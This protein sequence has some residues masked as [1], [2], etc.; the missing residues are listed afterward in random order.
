MG[1]LHVAAIPFWVCDSVRRSGLTIEAVLDFEKVSKVL[2]TRELV[3]LNALQNPQYQVKIFGAPLGVY[4][5]DFLTHWSTNVHPSLRSAVQKVCEYAEFNDV[6]EELRVR[7]FDNY[8][9]SSTV[10]NT[11]T[12]VPRFGIAVQVAPNTFFG[13]NHENNSKAISREVCARIYKY[14]GIGKLVSSPIGAGY[15]EKLMR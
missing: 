9:C 5:F 2:S 7:L 12:E 13:K 1:N 4:A 3:I 14:E 11:V 8:E 15:I 10:T 6:G